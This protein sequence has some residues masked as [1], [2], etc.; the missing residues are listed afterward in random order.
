MKAEAFVVQRIGYDMRRDS[1]GGV[2]P[3]CCISLPCTWCT[4]L[5]SF[6]VLVEI[7]ALESCGGECGAL[8]LEVSLDVHC[9]V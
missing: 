2:A 4:G 6:L 8:L 1:G 7:Y 3:R 9:V 5:W